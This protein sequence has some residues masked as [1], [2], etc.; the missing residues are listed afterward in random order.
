MDS[1]P[2]RWLVS[3]WQ[4]PRAALLSGL[5]LLA[6]FPAWWHAEG[7]AFALVYL[8]LPLYLVHQF[9]EHDH[10]RFRRFVNE[11]VAGGLNA[12]T[13]MA[14][15]VINSVLIWVL[16]TIVILLALFVDLGI[17]LIA[18]YATALNGITHAIGAVV[19]RS[20]NPGLLTSVVLFIPIG[21]LATYEV[22][23]TA[24]PSTG[25]QLLAIGMAVAVHVV[26][27][28]YILSRIRR[29]RRSGV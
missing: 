4:W 24:D 9:E 16:F 17:G 15:F 3:E 14:T 13:P 19:T 18:V 21:V 26:L 12:L 28:G 6:L 11:H 2:L 20:Y 27:F 5:F 25:L 1:G 8:Q 22:V 10:D 7:I 29:L 23:D